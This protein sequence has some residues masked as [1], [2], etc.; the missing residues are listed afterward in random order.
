[1]IVESPA[2]AKTIEKY[3]VKILPLKADSGK[4]YHNKK[5]TIS[6]N[7]KTNITPYHINHHHPLY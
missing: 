7:T 5:S 6:N 3:W 2:K 4:N 1:L